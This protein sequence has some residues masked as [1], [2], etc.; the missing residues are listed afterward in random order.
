[1]EEPVTQTLHVAALAAVV[2]VLSPVMKAGTVTTSLTGNFVF[3]N[4]VVLFQV[5]IPISEELAVYTTSAATG[6]FAPYLILWDGSGNQIVQFNGGEP[7]CSDGYSSPRPLVGCNDTFVQENSL[8]A[9]TYTVGLAQTNNFALGGLTDGFT[10]DGAAN[11]NYTNAGNPCGAGTVLFCDAAASF[12]ADTSDWTVSFAATNPL[13][14][15]SETVTE[16]TTVPETAPGVDC[17]A[18]MTLIAL[19]AGRRW[20]AK[21]V[22]PRHHS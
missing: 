1:V 7:T 11:R 22:N 16:V 2:A 13:G 15:A 4:D 10:Q 9:G 6:G 18:G 12:T 17:L 3:D 8:P 14:S 20:R 21:A 19:L 5:V